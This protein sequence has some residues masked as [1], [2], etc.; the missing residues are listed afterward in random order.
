MESNTLAEVWISLSLQSPITPVGGKLE[1]VGERL[2]LGACQRSFLV[3][4]IRT[5][6]Q[7]VKC[8]VRMELSGEKIRCIHLTSGKMGK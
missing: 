6:T 4:S 3:A 8:G 5:V 2:I 7:E 1:S